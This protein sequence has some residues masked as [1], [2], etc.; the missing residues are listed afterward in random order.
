MEPDRSYQTVCT[1]FLTQPPSH[2]LLNLHA[3]LETAI[4]ALQ[5][6]QTECTASPTGSL[7]PAGGRGYAVA[8]VTKTRLPFLVGKKR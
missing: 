5:W 7:C 1:L 4:P 3:T 6:A 8:V 2:P